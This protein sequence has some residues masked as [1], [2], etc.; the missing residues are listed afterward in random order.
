MNKKT[1]LFP[2]FSFRIFTDIYGYLWIFMACG[3]SVQMSW[4]L[5]RLVWETARLWALAHARSCK[6][7]IPHEL[8][9]SDSLLVSGLDP[10]QDSTFTPSAQGTVDGLPLNDICKEPNGKRTW[11]APSHCSH[12]NPKTFWDPW[13]LWILPWPWIA[14]SAVVVLCDQDLNFMLARPSFWVLQLGPQ[15]PHFGA[16]DFLA[17]PATAWLPQLG[18]QNLH[19]QTWSIWLER[20][21]TFDNLWYLRKLSYILRNCFDLQGL[22]RVPLPAQL[23]GCHA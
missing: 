14:A 15:L 11:T 13:I 4:L 19:L 23:S 6:W 1:Q 2:S 8:L 20:I 12:G 3:S 21:G 7:M 10:F 18:T 5:K 9:C 16:S 22:S 17:L